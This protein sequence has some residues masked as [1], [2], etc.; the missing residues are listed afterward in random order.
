MAEIATPIGSKLLEALQHSAS[1]LTALRRGIEKES[2]RVTQD[3]KLSCRP[4]PS[5]LG[6]PLTHPNI[7]TDFSEAQLELITDVQQSPEASIR[8]LERVHR[9]VY[10]NMEDELLWASSMPC[11]LGADSEIPVGRYGTSNI[12]KAKT[13]YRLGLGNRYGRLMQTISGIHYNFSVPDS[14]WPVLADY[15]GAQ[16]NQVFKTQSYFGL[17]RNF[18]RFSWLLIYLFGA[19]PAICRSFVKDRPHPL[20]P[21]DEGTLYLPFAT[22]LRMG[23]LGYQSDAQSSLHISYNS[24]DQYARSMHYALTQ[25]YP[26]YEKIGV[27][28]DG[29]YR[30]LNTSLIQIENEF[31]GT[32]RPKRPVEPGERPLAALQRRGVEYVEVRCLDLNPFLHVGID[33]PQIRFLDT[34][35]LY[36]LLVDSPADSERES[37]IMGDNQ[38]AI[39]E[40]GR[41]PGLQLNRLQGTIAREAWAHEILNGCRPLAELLDRAHGGEDYIQS[42]EE[43]QR[44]VDKPELTPSA[45]ILDLMA[46]QRIPFFRFTMNQSLAHKGYFDEHPLRNRQLADYRRQAEASLAEQALIEAADS[47]DFDTFLETYLAMD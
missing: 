2:L 8:Q 22:S 39:V 12:A 44:K 29:E 21:F 34:F 17:I 10:Q 32:I 37:Q 41:E 30:Q 13:V 24:L 28:V 40:R 31:Y 4:H 36:C 43:Q 42:W 14:F 15:V 27:K 25:P 47:V 7:T 33:E 16:P 1:I 20:Q 5:G 35:L 11:I 6:S 19:S 46:S 3:G 38:L 9:F 18:R 23:R 45:R 26:A